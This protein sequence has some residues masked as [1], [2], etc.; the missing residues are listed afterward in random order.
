[1]N[2]YEKANW[3]AIDELMVQAGLLTH[4]GHDVER[5]A[6]FQGDFDQ[7]TGTACYAMVHK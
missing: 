4:D 1:M 3:K 7:A 2:F 6:T 5:T